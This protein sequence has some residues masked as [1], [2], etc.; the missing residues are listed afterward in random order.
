MER[1]ICVTRTTNQVVGL[2]ILLV[3]IALLVFVFLAAYHMYQSINAGTFGLEPTLHTAPVTGTPSH[4]LPAGALSANPSGTTPVAAALILFAK[5]FALLV[6]GWL[7]GLLAS[8]GVALATG[9]PHKQ[10]A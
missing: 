8:K 4:P 7:A 6:M 1:H 3:G 9:T 2:V 5:L 10:Q